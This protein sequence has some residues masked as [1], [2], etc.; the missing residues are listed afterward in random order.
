MYD[1]SGSS[2]L[3]VYTL[4]AYCFL[5]RPTGRGTLHGWSDVMIFFHPFYRFPI[6]DC[7]HALVAKTLFLYFVIP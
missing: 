5:H 4:L 3:Y 1:M 7:Y 2:S 6:I